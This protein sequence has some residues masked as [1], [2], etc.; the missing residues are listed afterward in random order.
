[1]VDLRNVLEKK[2]QLIFQFIKFGI[3]GVIGTLIDIGILN[4]LHQHFGISVYLAATVAFVVAVINNFLF[5][6]YW[7]FKNEAGYQSKSHVQFIQ[8]IFISIVG[9]LINLGIMYLLIEYFDF[10]F[11][12]AKLAAIIVVLFWNFIANKLWT[13]RVNKAE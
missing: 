1:M 12:W 6:K 8:F 4:Y 2:K 13:F 10:W 5:N 7:T 3:V 11:N 9:L